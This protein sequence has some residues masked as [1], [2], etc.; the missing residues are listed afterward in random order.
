[1]VFVASHGYNDKK[2]NFYILPVKGDPGK[3]RVTGVSWY[4]FSDILGNLPSKVLL[5]LDTCH[6][7]QL[8]I[9]ML[10]M[11][12]G[13]D[14]VT[15]ILR[16]ISSDENGVIVFSASTGKESSMESSE[17]KH[18]AFTKAILEGLENGKADYNNNGIIHVRELDNYLA[19]RV[20]KLTKGNQ[21]TT[22][23]KPSTISIMPIYKIK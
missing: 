23:L 5:F 7:G 11:L 18:G 8:G 9:K 14:D 1:M 6:S 20:K 3:L 16:E 17:W 22:T 12:R 2:G 21:H 13:Q 19:E 4:E 15:D 10:T